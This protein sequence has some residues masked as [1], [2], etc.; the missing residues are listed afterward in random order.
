MKKK[1][2]VVFIL[3]LFNIVAFAQE[4][5]FNWDIALSS[6]IPIHSSTTE[7][8]KTEILI[9]ADFKR[10]IAGFTGD[11]VINITEPVKFGLGADAFCEFLWDGSA[12]HNSL[13]YSFHGGIK[14]YP[15]LGGF[16]FSIAYV[17][18]SEYTFYN[19]EEAGKS[20]YASAWGNGFRFAFEYDFFYNEEAKVYPIVGGYYKFMPRGNYTFDHI[21]AVYAGLRL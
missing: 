20:D 10:I 5:L 13:D 18:G 4:R 15:N 3:I 16:N 7:S 8:T 19:T 17:F 6:G 2:S 1:I 9:N 11:V 12:H 14:I 21:I